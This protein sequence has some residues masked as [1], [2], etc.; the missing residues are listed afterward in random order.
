MKRVISILLVV[1]MTLGLFAGCAKQ[2]EEE[3]YSGDGATLTVGVPQNFAIASYDDNAFTKYIE[4]TL[5]INI[6]FEYFPSSAEYYSQQLSLMATS[7]EKMPD[8]L[9]GFTG[10]GTVPMYDF[11]DDGYFLDLTDLIEEHAVY[12]KEQF[13]KLTKE[14]QDRITRKGTSQTGGFY[15][16]PLLTN[17]MVDNKANLMFINQKWLDKLGLKAPTNIEELYDVL[18]AFKTQDPNGNGVAD[19]IPLL[20]KSGT[21]YD[22]MGYM[23]NAFT[24]YDLKNKFNVEDGK[25]V[26][27]YISDEYRESLK[28][29]R[30]LNAEGLLSDLCFSLSGL[31]DFSA[32]IT[33]TDGVAKVGIWSGHPSLFTNV[34]SPVL[35]E[36][37]ALG[38]LDDATGKG[39]YTVIWEN[40][41]YFC[42]FITKDCQ[43]P[44]LAMKFLDLFY[45]DETVTRARFGEK[46]VDWEVGE[47]TDL[48]G[49]DTTIKILNQQAFF[50]GS[51]T[52]GQNGN[53]IFTY[54]NY[55]SICDN[56]RAT[57]KILVETWE[58]MKNS[59]RCETTSEDLVYTSDE[60]AEKSPIQSAIDSYVFEHRNLFI[61]GNQDP[62]SDADWNNYLKTLDEIGLD[63]MT[64]YAQK[65]YDRKMGV[66]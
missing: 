35:E 59:K 60:Y 17:T 2:Q 41:L 54:E 40:N 36:Y 34:N 25:L 65:A 7:G 37:V 23:I 50:E 5:N 56:T 3:A 63:K 55:S 4:D 48:Y 49:N 1:C 13:A 27:N 32:V 61:T 21:D 38:S 42:S 57:D 9:W 12:Y 6:K 29:M 30:K 18:T 22:V 43:N 11:G 47:G 52:W 58:I 62:N 33:P 66:E 16:M 39:G 53:S 24:Y 15:G 8:V 20:G 10:L 14:E 64:E 44:E 45:K 28:F 19:E 31:T 51:Q 26:A 46:G